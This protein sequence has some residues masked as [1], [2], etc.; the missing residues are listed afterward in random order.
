MSFKSKNNLD[1]INFIKN[2][3]TQDEINNDFFDIKKFLLEK[4]HPLEFK[5]NDTA[6]LWNVIRYIQQKHSE[7]LK[8]DYFKDES[9]RVR[10]ILKHGDPNQ[11][12]TLL[13]IDK[14][15]DKLWKKLIQSIK[16]ED[17]EAFL[18]VKRLEKLANT[19]FEE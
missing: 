13:G 7:F 8:D 18:E 11:R 14:K 16:N 3:E 15:K 12:I 6:E 5:A 2:I 10:F 19:E 1:K 4:L 9:A 17:S